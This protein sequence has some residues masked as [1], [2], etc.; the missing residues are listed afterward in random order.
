MVQEHMDLSGKIQRDNG[1]E[2]TW[3]WEHGV[4]NSFG[5]MVQEKGTLENPHHHKGFGGTA[6]SRPK[7]FPNFLTV[8]VCLPCEGL[9]Q[10]QTPVDINKLDYLP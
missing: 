2:I 7:L 9:Q 5:Y 4:G 8:R 3:G 1:G 6:C 10:F